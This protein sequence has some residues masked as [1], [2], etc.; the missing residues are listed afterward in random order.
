MDDEIREQEDANPGETVDPD[1]AEDAEAPVDSAAEDAEEGAAAASGEAEPGAEAEASEASEA[2]AEAADGQA[3]DIAAEASEA[4]APGDAAAEAVTEAKPVE[5]DMGPERR[6]NAWVWVGLLIGVLIAGSAAGYLWW[7][8]TS[9]SLPV[10][11]VVGKLP[12][13]AVQIINDGGLRLGEVSEEPTDT[14]LPGTVIEQVPPAGTEMKPGSRVSF[15]IAASPTDA[16]V[17]EVTGRTEE[18]A[19]R[20]LARANLFPVRVV[21]YSPAVPAGSVASQV[22]TAGADLAPGSP[23]AL[24]ISQGPAP[25]QMRVPRVIGLTEVDAD[26]LIGAWN[27]RGVSYRSFDA[28]ISAGTVM[29]QSM[30]ANAVVGYDAVLQYLISDGA[31]TAAAVTV[32]DVVGKAQATAEKSFKDLGLKVEVHTMSHASVAKGSVITQMPPSG[33]KVAKNGTV[34]IVVSAGAATTAAMPSVAGL[35]S[36]E[37]SK[38]VV[39]AG[40]TPLAIEIESSEVAGTVIGQYPIPGVQWGLRLP[41]VFVVSKR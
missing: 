15:V 40:L 16:T 19:A 39:A 27:L 11:N 20:A 32:P 3:E 1:A 17:P 35:S 23:V 21:V 25:S 2:T 28:S 29:A 30:D 7:Y 38:A 34:G 36:E 12:A 9:R 24:V 10:P 41:V 4:P 6:T 5:I 33:R 14:A 26:K 22:P 8:S 13:D 31:G 37:A 18:E